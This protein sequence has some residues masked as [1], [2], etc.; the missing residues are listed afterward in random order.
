MFR[1]FW[2]VPFVVL[3]AYGGIQPQIL[4]QSAPKQSVGAASHA[5]ARSGASTSSRT[6]DHDATSVEAGGTYKHAGKMPTSS[7]IPSSGPP[8]SGGATY[9][10]SPT[11]SNTN[12]G[13]AE[14]PFRTIQNAADTVNPGDTVIVEDGTYTSSDASSCS[15]ETTVVCVSRGGT[16]SNWVVFKSR[17]K[18][19]ARI[20]GQNSSVNNGWTF[21]D[22]S[23]YVRIEGFEIFGVGNANGSS[24]GIN[25]FNGGHDVEIAG[26]HIHHVG[27]VCTDTSNAQTGITVKR[28]RATIEENL[29]HDIGRL[30]PGENGCNPDGF[31]YE[32]HDH[33]IYIN[34]NS[35]NPSFV[36]NGTMVRNNIFYN[37]NRGW[38]VHMFPGALE[39]VSILN[40]TFATPNPYRDGHIV[41]S[42][43]D[44]SDSRIE[45]NIFYEPRNLAVTIRGGATVTNTMI[46]HNI[47]TTAS[48]TDLIPVGLGLANNGLNTD[49]LL[50]NAADSDFRLRFNSPAIDAG[51]TLS[52]VTRDFDGQTRPRGAASDIGARE[53]VGSAP[54]IIGASISGKHLLVSGEAFDKGAIIL[55]NGSSQKTLHDDANP[56]VLIGK[57]VGKRIASGQRVVLQVRNSDGLLS[58]EFS[59]TRP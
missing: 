11:G 41:I 2:F 26:N 13:T 25:L 10:V 46:T 39:R 45:N 28:N 15:R 23:G 53:F 50:V 14:L 59:F 3:T 43:V 21:G 19:R 36:A 8:Q 37:I 40:N 9:Y 24:S 20:D 57:K 17:N 44:L 58:L 7:V 22:E 51:L 4:A 52:K 5:V 49:P 42:G 16:A 29:I 33:G 27:R 56:T 6:G 48:M 35:N 30:A 38:P 55:M 47:T 12:P 32:N 31:N 34:G 18:W 1:C 54:T